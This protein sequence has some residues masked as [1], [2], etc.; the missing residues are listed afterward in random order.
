MVIDTTKRLYR[1]TERRNNNGVQVTVYIVATGT[2]QVERYY[3]EADDAEL[4][5]MRSIGTANVIGE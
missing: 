2:D 1:V 5:S 4:I 3:A